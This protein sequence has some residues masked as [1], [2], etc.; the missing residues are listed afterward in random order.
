[1]SQLPLSVTAT[2]QMFS[3][4]TSPRVHTIIIT[5]A[6]T[7]IQVFL[8][9]VRVT[10]SR[11]HVSGM[12]HLMTLPAIQIA[13]NSHSTRAGVVTTRGLG[14]RDDPEEHQSARRSFVYPLSGTTCR[15]EARP[16]CIGSDPPRTQTALTS[17]THVPIDSVRT[18][19][20]GTTW[21][22][23]LTSRILPIH[24]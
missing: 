18:C 23:S 8:G 16:R 1:M 21:L 12:L 7:Y 24:T 3:K 22:S 4:H 20:S 11:G 6:S 15:P 13:D 2:G 10:G 5:N 17:C 9:D 14:C 19:P